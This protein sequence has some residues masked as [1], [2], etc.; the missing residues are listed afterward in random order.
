MDEPTDDNATSEGG[1]NGSVSREAAIEPLMNVLAKFRDDVKA[2]AGNGP[3]EV[4][5]ISDVLRDDVLPHHNIMLED[6][7]PGEPAIW[8]FVDYKVI[9]AER[10]EKLKVKQKKEE[11]KR[12]KK[13]LDERKKSTPASEWFKSEFCKQGEGYSKF[14][15]Q[16]IPT[17]Q[18]KEKKGKKDEAAVK[19]EKEVPEAIR[20]KLKK[21]WNK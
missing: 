4:F 12:V 16:G 1:Q 2:N 6:R 8:K 9:V 3:K 21:E 7:K 17:H 5:Q 18:I 20:N 11:E 15:E 19:E 13:I 10:E 14:D